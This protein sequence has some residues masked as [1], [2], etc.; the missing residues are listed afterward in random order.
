MKNNRRELMLAA[1]KLWSRLVAHGFRHR[2]IACGQPGIDSHHWLYRRSVH[3]YR[4]VLENGIYMC[5]L[6]HNAVVQEEGFRYRLRKKIETDYP[7]LD[8]WARSRPLLVS[9]PL[10]TPWIEE[11]VADMKHTAE[12]LGI[13][14][15][16]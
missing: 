5:R 1:D 8:K 4:W 16:I 14:G 3:Q 6:C 12:I 2:C 9:R 7:H 11:R 10:P 15:A 13:S